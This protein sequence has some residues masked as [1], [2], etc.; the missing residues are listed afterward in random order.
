[1]FAKTCCLV[2]YAVISFVDSTPIRACKNKR[3]SRN[4]V[5][6]GVAKTGKSTMGWFHGFKLHI[7]ID[8]KGELLSFVVG[9]ANVNYTKLLTK[10]EFLKKKYLESYL[11][12]KVIYLINCKN[13]FI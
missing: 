6:K 1:M 11:V 3:I 9:Q 10:I 7:V 8:D 12:A 13:Y 2:N 5:S 4:M